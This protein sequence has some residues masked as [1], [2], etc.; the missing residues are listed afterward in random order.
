[1]GD[2]APQLA[3]VAQ[4]VRRVQQA[5]MAV[6]ETVVQVARLAKRAMGAKVPQVMPAHPLVAQA[7]RAVTQA[8][9]PG[10]VA[11]PV[12]QVLVLAMRALQ[13]RRVP[14]AL[15]SLRVATVVMAGL[16]TPIHRVM[17]VTVVLVVRVA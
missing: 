3:Q 14:T 9:M 2:P 4:V 6:V 11:Q 17:A 7:D 1:M 5:P 16:V 15:M 13:A 12:R 8:R 10:W